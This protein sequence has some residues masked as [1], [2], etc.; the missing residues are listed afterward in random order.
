MESD[1]SYFARRA[2]EERAAAE[3]APHP[4]A[5]HSHMEMALRYDDMAAATSVPENNVGLGD[6][7]HAKSPIA[8]VRSLGG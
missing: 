4:G 8:G 3:R 7:P 5:K 6:Y 1:K 2:A